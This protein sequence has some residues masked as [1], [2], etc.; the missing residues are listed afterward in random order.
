MD[1]VDLQLNFAMC[2]DHFQHN[3][4]TKDKDEQYKTPLNSTD[5]SPNNESESIEVVET[6]SNPYKGPLQESTISSAS[7]NNTDICVLDSHY[8]NDELHFLPDEH[9]FV[10][11]ED[12]DE[13]FLRA[14][15]VSDDN[16]DFTLLRKVKSRRL[17]NCDESTEVLMLINSEYQGKQNPTYS[18]TDS[19]VEVLM[20]EEVVESDWSSGNNDNKDEKSLTFETEP[21]YEEGVA[22]SHNQLSTDSDISCA[23]LG[24]NSENNKYAHLDRAQLLQIIQQQE[25]RIQA[26]EATVEQYHKAQERLFQHVDA[27][28]LELNEIRIT[29]IQKGSMGRKEECWK[30]L[31]CGKI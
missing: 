3:E 2:F 6:P 28:R 8:A 31:L 18:G 7:T 21:D 22:S 14:T 11:S 9:E 5:A 26:L 29:P 20:S 27:L 17:C 4:T 15:D 10:E 24:V 1:D 13:V 12:G 16:G 23:E 19:D 25:E 30:L